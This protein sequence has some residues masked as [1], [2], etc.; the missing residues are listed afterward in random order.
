MSAR[1]L[2]VIPAYHESKRLPNFLP[3][4]C[5]VAA[6]AD[7]PI[8]I[9]IVDD[10]SGPGEQDSLE[11]FLAPVREKY[12]FVRPLRRL[13]ANRGKGEAVYSGWDLADGQLW[14]AFV[15]ADGAVPAAEVVRLSQMVSNP[16]LAGKAIFAVRLLGAGRTVKRTLARL[17]TGQVFR[18][19]VHALFDLPVPD[20]QCG[21]KIIPASW[22]R[23]IRGQLHEHRFCF[24]V[25]LTCI[26]LRAGCRIESV[27]IDW[28]ESPGGRVHPRAIYEMLASLLRLRRRLD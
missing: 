24:D 27:P 9:Q 11:Q 14:L 23:R 25:E 16:E 3:G 5:E 12:P 15:D 19:L 21:F 7:V 28:H 22:Y 13:E 10:G 8:D 17:I 1:I 18:W 26:L 4:L 2:L 6:A 20:T